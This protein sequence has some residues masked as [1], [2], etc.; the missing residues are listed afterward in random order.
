MFKP[1]RIIEKDNKRFIVAAFPS[2]PAM[3][4]TLKN[5]GENN[6][7]M[8]DCKSSAKDNDRDNWSGTDTLETAYNLAVNGW[9]DPLDKLEKGFAARNA[10]TE[11]TP[12]PR[13]LV[14]D[15]VGCLPL[16]PAALAGVPFTML[17]QAQAPKKIK[18]MRLFY[19]VSVNWT[20]TADE[21][22]NSG[23]T[24]LSLIKALELGG[25]RVRLDVLSFCAEKDGEYFLSL[26]TAKDYRQPIDLKKLAFPF[27]NPAYLRRIGFRALET[28]DGLTKGG[29]AYGYGHGLETIDK[30]RAALE[31]CGLVGDNDKVTTIKHISGLGYDVARLARELGVTI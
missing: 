5:A 10:Q 30:A 21:M 2:I 1:Y 6:K 22:I 15:M 9:G 16:V 11:T 27:V 28:V 20:T 3:I 4:N 31:S 17:R 24:L 18:T 14:P 19:A 23:C 13:G 12:A 26:A 29:F 7:V 8:S 25:W